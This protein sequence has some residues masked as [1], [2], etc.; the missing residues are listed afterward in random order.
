MSKNELVIYRSSAGS[1]KTYTLVFEYL[2]LV[3]QK[4][5]LYRSILAITFTNKATEEM[6]SR[7]VESLVAIS[8]NKEEDLQKSLSTESG[9]PLQQITERAAKVLDYILH[10][11]SG[12]AVSTIDSFF[13]KMVRSL[14]RELHLPLRFDIELDSGA[15]IREITDM[16]FDHISKDPWLRKWLEN[17]IFDKLEDEKGWKIEE[18]IHKIARQLFDEKYRSLFAEGSRKPENELITDLKKL[19]TAFEKKMAAFGIDFYRIISEN[20]L[21]MEDFFQGKNGVAGYFSKIQ[22]KIKSDAYMPGARFMNALE[23]EDAWVTKKSP[24]GDTIKELA[25]AKLIPLA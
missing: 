15:V 13:S 9:I 22:K 25:N 3:L 23:S 4:P 17:F 8:E 18:D 5:S 21:V 12:F 7:I 19:I 2:K 1:G 16:L 14:A 24:K 6:K 10:D 20:G 11:Y